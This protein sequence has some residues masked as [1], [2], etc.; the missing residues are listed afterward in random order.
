MLLIIFNLFAK[1][2][3]NNKIIH[4]WLPQ[5]LSTNMNRRRYKNKALFDIIFGIFKILI[6]RSSQRYIYCQN[7]EF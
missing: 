2:I 6:G 3:K 5:L 1:F 4:Q 7:F